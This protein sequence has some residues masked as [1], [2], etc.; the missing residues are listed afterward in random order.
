MPYANVN[1]LNL[2]YEDHGPRTGPA[3]ILTPGGR[4]D[5]NGLRP[6]AALLSA[7][8]RVILHDRRNC[9]KSD[10]L[11]AG[12]L[13][14]QHHW[15]EEMADLLLQLDA[16][17]AYVAGGSA[18]SRTSLTL[19]ARRP[20]VVKA[21]FIWEVSG[22]PNSAAA[23]SPNYYGQFIDA[24]RAGGM[25]AVAETEYFAQRIVDNPANEAVLLSMDP[26]EFISVM[27][28]WQDSYSVPNPVSDLTEDQLRSIG[29]P[30]FM[31]EGN[32]PDEV[33]HVSAAQAAHRLIPNS[34]LRP[35]A[36]THAEWDIVG[37]H[38]HTFPGIAATNRYHMKA[39]FYAAQ[40]ME[41]IARVEAMEPVKVGQGD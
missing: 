34:E 11:I 8:Y 25:Q 2:Y 23:T 1:G 27:S 19:A 32:T 39:T 21:V 22:G 18:G 38:D 24:A 41:F 37:Q 29:C 40:L 13:S 3:I 4:N 16:A 28:R 7:K 33:H 10:I 5:T 9:G 35:S 14:E 17:P 36:W 30:V 20:E 12:E 31:F 15:A 6:L 26:A